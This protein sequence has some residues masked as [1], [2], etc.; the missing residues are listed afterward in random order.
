M[1][2][3]NIPLMIGVSILSEMH[4]YFRESGQDDLK[5]ILNISV[6]IKGINSY[7]KNCEASEQEY[8]NSS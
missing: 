7:L 6:V 1:D 2:R 4:D 3:D 8:E 5:H